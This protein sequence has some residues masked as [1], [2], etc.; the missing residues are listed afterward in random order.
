MNRVSAIGLTVYLFMHLAALGQLAL[1]PQAYDGFIAL[2]RNPIFMAGEFVVVVGGLLH[3]LNGLRLA[4]T[5]IGIGAAYQKQ[6]FYSFMTLA[7]V[8]ILYFGF[9]MF[10]GG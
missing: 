1:G 10:G 8:A 5:S 7:L 9:V 4:I 2:V 3:G 6:I